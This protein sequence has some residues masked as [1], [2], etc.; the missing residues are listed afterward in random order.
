LSKLE[1]AS[2]FCGA[3]GLDSGFVQQG[4]NIG[5]AS[6]VSPAARD[7]YHSNFGIYPD[8]KGVEN[9]SSADLSGADVILAGPPCQGF[10]NLGRRDPADPRNS[11]IVVAAELIAA[12][13]PSAFLIENV[14]GI[15]W[16]AGGKY[17]E[18]T[19]ETL[20]KA[21][22][23]VATIEIDCARLGL[24]QRRRRILFVGGRGS[25]GRT[26]VELVRRLAA[27]TAPRVTVADV[28]L[29]TPPL[30]AISNHEYPSYRAEWY[31]CIIDKLKPG[32]KLCDTRLG[33]SALHSWDVPEVFGVVSA[34]ER[35]ILETVAQLRRRVRRHEWA[36]LGDGRPIAASDLASSLAVAESALAASVERLLDRGYLQSKNG[37]LD[38]SRRFNGRFRRLPLDGHAPA[39]M[40]DFGSPR[41]IV[42][43]TEPRG[44]TVRE[45]AR[46]QGFRDDFVF[47]GSRPEQYQLVANAFPPT[48]AA[49]LAMGFRDALSHPVL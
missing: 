34:F 33:A 49:N 26:V 27:T 12:A 40:R 13:R 25:T 32:Q 35:Q 39:V 28:L 42:H 19:A 2:L 38:L 17:A 41:T 14:P 5:I 23:D 18:L 24:A 9:L 6:D 10:S 44:L 1:V 3:G 15:R 22:L 46:L 29:P 11:L 48:L 36:H 47:R 21:G 45:C 30:G 37:L 43:P 7:T 31:N 4:W 16:L 20:T 8:S